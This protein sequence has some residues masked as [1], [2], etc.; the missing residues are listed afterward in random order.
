MKYS[1]SR[2]WKVFGVLLIALPWGKYSYAQP[3][4]SS[5]RLSWEDTVHNFIYDV[6]S[7]RILYQN[8]SGVFIR[9]RQTDLDEAIPNSKDYP[10]Q[11]PHRGFLTPDG[12]VFL[13]EPDPFY[14]WSMFHWKNGMLV[15]PVS[16]NSDTTTT[17]IVKGN[18]AIWNVGSTLSRRDLTSEETTVISMD[19]HTNSNDVA[20]N[21]DVVYWTGQYRIARWRNGQTE[22]FPKD[23]GFMNTYP[24]TDGTNIVYESKKTDVSYSI[25][26]IT[27]TGETSLVDSDKQLGGYRINNGWVAYQKNW[28]IWLRSPEGAIRQI[29]PDSS[30]HFLVGLSPNGEVLTRSSNVHFYLSDFSTDQPVDLGLVPHPDWVGFRDGNWY[31]TNELI[32]VD[33]HSNNVQ[34]VGAELY[35]VNS[36]WRSPFA[37]DQS[38]KDWKNDPLPVT[39]KTDSPQGRPLTYTVGTPAH[40][41]LTGTPPNLTYQPSPD[42][43]GADSFTFQASD[44]TLN[45]QTATV[46]INVADPQLLIGSDSALPRATVSLPVRLAPLAGNVASLDI[47]FHVDK[48]ANAPSVAPTLSLTDTTAGWQI[49]RDSSDPLHLSIASANGVSGDVALLTFTFTIPSSTP[50]G[51]IYT[52]SAATASVSDEFGNTRSITGSVKEGHVTVENVVPVANDLS[53]SAFQDHPVAVR[54]QATSGDSDKLTLRIVTPPAHGDL[55]GPTTN[56]TYTPQP[57]YFGEDSFTYVANDT[58]TDSALATVSLHVQ[59]ALLTIGSATTGQGEGV[60]LPISITDSASSVNSLDLTLTS[61]VTSL[62]PQWRLADDGADWQLQ[63]DPNNP[64]HVTLTRDTPVSGPS[65]L[66]WLSVRPPANATIGSTIPVDVSGFQLGAPAITTEKLRVSPGALTIE[67]CHD[68]IRGDLNGDG[69]VGIGDAI[70]ALRMAVLLNEPSNPCQRAAGDVNCDGAINIGDAVLI[71]RNVALHEEFPA[72]SG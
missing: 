72:C 31:I 27:P 28:G 16:M 30:K 42:F 64:R 56:L 45:S 1:G 69:A 13:V 26:L 25:R 2:F 6:S 65:V 14:T 17:L 68:R 8:D 60:E 62:E 70:L 40:G 43:V 18:Y 24:L 46:S 47:H 5:P 9:N 19:A 53:V 21:G 52:V 58:H 35:R 37:S 33:P 71:L 59:P 38:F 50:P 55:S 10:K 54:L 15:A 34:F 36:D 23:P 4:V 51:T 7:D 12:A 67:A 20:E 3:Q 66:L 32:T 11:T 61:N 41:S 29:V 44:G 48:T 57:G 49:V 22:F 39:L 63:V